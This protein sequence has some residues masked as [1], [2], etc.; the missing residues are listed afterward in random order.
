MLTTEPML[1]WFSTQ[2]PSALNWLMSMLYIVCVICVKPRV[3]QDYGPD[4]FLAR[5]GN[6]LEH[7]YLA[8]NPG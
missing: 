4:Y 7:C 1:A 6:F 2:T 3:M 5:A 8:S